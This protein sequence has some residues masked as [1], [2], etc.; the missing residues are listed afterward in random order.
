MRTNIVIDDKLMADVMAYGDFKT[1]RE[2]VEAGLKMLKRR[3]A[4]D[5]LLAARGTLHW[6]DSDE[7]WAR[8]RAE[9]N[10]VATGVDKAAAQAE[11]AAHEPA[12]PY[13]PASQN[14]HATAASPKA[15]RAKKVTVK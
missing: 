10:L 3:K 7:A 9:K 13:I 8:R 1:K 6:D 5:A 4:Y 2:A 15:R 14:P 11:Q 12:A